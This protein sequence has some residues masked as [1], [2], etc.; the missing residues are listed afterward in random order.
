MSVRRRFR[1][2]GTARASDGVA[3]S[4]K[5]QVAENHFWNHQL[6]RQRT[7]KPIRK[8]KHTSPSLISLSPTALSLPLPAPVAA[9]RQSCVDCGNLVPSKVERSDYDSIAA[10][11][12]VTSH[13]DTPF[14][15]PHL[16]AHCAYREAEAVHHSRRQ[17]QKA[18]DKGRGRESPHRYTHRISLLPLSTVRDRSQG[19]ASL[20]TKRPPWQSPNLP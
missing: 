7:T 6:H 14:L 11:T 9:E 3:K 8:P 16:H 12:L 5:S 2:A 4:W 15:I 13:A 18:L 20:T 17:S 1:S 19:P 10:L